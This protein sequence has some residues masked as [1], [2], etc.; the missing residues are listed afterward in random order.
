M[1][2]LFGIPVNCELL[3]VCLVTKI[4]DFKY[5]LQILTYLDVLSG[6]FLTFGKGIFGHVKLHIRLETGR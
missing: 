2:L 5:K 4:V 6:E 1:P 3:C